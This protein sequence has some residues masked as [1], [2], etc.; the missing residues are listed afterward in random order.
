MFARWTTTQAEKERSA[1]PL[2]DH[3]LRCVGRLTVHI[4]IADSPRS[5]MAPDHLPPPTSGRRKLR[6]AVR[7]IWVLRL[8][9]GRPVRFDNKK[10]A[11][12]NPINPA[13]WLL[14]ES[15][16]WLYSESASSDGDGDGD[17]DDD[18]HGG[19][20]RGSDDGGGQGGG[21]GRGAGKGG[22]RSGSAKRAARAAASFTR[23]QV[24]Q[25]KARPASAGLLMRKHARM[26]LGFGGGAAAGG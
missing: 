19:G 2:V 12:L 10:G 22:G 26:T 16:A 17:G 18:Q 15:E 14:S 25:P 13:V 3:G 23:P 4:A 11:A 24:Q 9:T 5:R 21:E 1:R 7:A 20:G 6:R 8:W